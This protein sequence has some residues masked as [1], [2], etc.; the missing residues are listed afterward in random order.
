MEGGVEPGNRAGGSR[1]GGSRAGALWSGDWS[2]GR[3][4]D[5][6]NPSHGDG[7]GGSDGDGEGEDG[8]GGEG[9]ENGCALPCRNRSSS[10]EG[11]EGLSHHHHSAFRLF[12]QLADAEG[13]LERENN[14]QL[15]LIAVQVNR[16]I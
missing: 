4:D 12:R 13:S 2:G 15:E 7:D 11:M 1:A 3:R 10:T 14:V 6:S 16:F 9:G 8:E 5:S